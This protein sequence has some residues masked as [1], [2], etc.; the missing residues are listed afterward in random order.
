MQG[1]GSQLCD[2]LVRQVIT[3]VENAT[4]PR[5]AALSAY[6]AQKITDDPD[7]FMCYAC[8]TPV[9]KY[10]ETNIYCAENHE[11][12]E[13]EWCKGTCFCLVACG[14]AWCVPRKCNVC[15]KQNICIGQT[16]CCD[17]TDCKNVICEDCVEEGETACSVC[18]ADRWCS[19]HLNLKSYVLDCLNS[20][21]KV[22]RDVCSTCLN[23]NVER[24][25]LNCYKC[26]NSFSRLDLMIKIVTEDT[27]NPVGYPV[28]K[29]CC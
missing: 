22:L 9:R 18:G 29:N 24:D 25:N 8:N 27:Q 17:E 4:A 2:Y 3:H 6:V 15:N 21:F 5:L 26:K 28:C 23:E 20:N 12:H 14:R 10:A 11:C 1:L 7:F 16:Y 13:G 19:D